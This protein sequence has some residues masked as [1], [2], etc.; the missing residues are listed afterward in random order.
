MPAAIAAAVAAASVATALVLYRD[1][2]RDATARRNSVA[3][4]MRATMVSTLSAS[5]GRLEELAT[6]AGEHWPATEDEFDA[7]AG[8]ILRIDG[9]DRVALIRYV[10]RR[11]RARWERAHGPI[12][13][14]PNP[15]YAPTQTASLDA[16][17]ARGG[18]PASAKYRP[19]PPPGGTPSPG[20]PPP[21]GAPPRSDGG[22]PPRG[23]AGT[24][25]P[26]GAGTSRRDG[27]SPP[28]RVG[29]E[30]RYFVLESFIGHGSAEQPLGVD[31]A[32][33][34]T[35]AE[36]LLLAATSG[37]PQAGRASER[38]TA[39]TSA[40]AK[41]SAAAR[42]KGEGERTTELYV[43]VYGGG[44]GGRSASARLGSLRGFI[45]TR[46]R[47]D[48]LGTALSAV[49]DAE[50]IAY[51]LREGGTT[52]VAR[53]APSQPRSLAVTI[54]G[55][56]LEL[57]VGTPATDLSAMLDALL[58]GGAL[59]VLL[60]VISRATVRR[61][62]YALSLAQQRTVERELA[63]SALAV[64]ENRF[65]TAFS[66]APIGM[67]LVS[68]DGR[69]TQVNEALA[70]IVGRSEEELIDLEVTELIDP[71]DRAAH[72]RALAEL[73][74]GEVTQ[75]D[76]ERRFLSTSGEVAWV[77]THTTLIRDED[78]RPAY[79]LSQ[80]EDVS[81]RRRYESRLQHL[82]DHD[83]LT[84]LLNRRA[85]DDA[86]REHVESAAGRE[87]RGGVMVLDLDDFKQVNDTLGHNAGD[88]LI[89]R[90]AHALSSRLRSEDAIARLGGDEFAILLRGGGRAELELL[91]RELLG[92]VREQRAARGP[93][94]R[95]RPVSASLGIA[96]LAL[97]RGSTADEVLTA[98]DL[99]MY[100]A[101]EAGRDRAE[102]YGGRGGGEGRQ[103]R[104]ESHL[105]WVE[106]IRAALDENTL[107]LHA[108]PVA[109]TWTLRMTQYELLIRMRDDDGSLI[110]PGRFLPVAERYGLMKELDRWVIGAAIKLLEQQLAQGR[111]P[112]VE[113]NLSG[114]SLGDADL[115]EHVGRELAVSEA[116]ATQLIFEVTETAAIGNMA[117]ARSCAE[118][119]HALGC[120]FALDD[121]GA[122]FGSFYYLKHLPFDFIKIDGEFVRKC[123]SNATDRLVVKAVVDLARGLGKRTVAEFVGDP[124][125][126][127]ILRD[128]GVD[129]AQGFHIGRPA[130]LSD[131]LAAAEDG[132]P[133]PDAAEAQRDADVGADEPAAT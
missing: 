118:Q 92:I 81:A 44:G 11:E 4:R 90:V 62:R 51:A 100:D 42:T 22:T 133:R 96:P 110:P 21:P 103:A 106:R 120:R 125:T 64:A 126:L 24:P 83:P 72:A 18:E 32:S 74:G 12:V 99:A 10:T 3:R 128:L 50:G 122:G 31:L 9:V 105:A 49:G 33:S 47:Y 27:V 25:R 69:L 19:P 2:G 112:V 45:A 5:I 6:A 16:G 8:G 115:A 124:E 58:G 85:Y 39:A 84:G 95:E 57:A 13:A 23:G 119:L 41:R 52:L 66:Q 46:Y 70:R 80:L 53:G 116:L 20:A 17:A 1:A 61:E 63:E 78:E 88:D 60:I 111:R 54:A 77:S 89:A 34:T 56:S 65:R 121:F 28:S 129:Y 82:A 76:G 15:D 108:Q 117:A 35:R 75:I 109:E 68:L 102:T 123:V 132:A 87:G 48:T 101:K 114:Q 30:A 38:A 7:L 36:A 107:V 97:M 73:G 131:W 94:G 67:A 104:I 79:L 55:R 37:R 113:L 93:G 14:M 40:S 71:A 98:A 43:P 29:R 127:R 91:A 59:T 26:G 130:P 86:L